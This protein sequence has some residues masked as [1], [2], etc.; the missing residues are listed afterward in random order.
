M[1]SDS[2]H[3]NRAARRESEVGPL[4][5]LLR[6]ADE[7]DFSPGLLNDLASAMECKLQEI[8]PDEIQ[9]L[10]SLIGKPVALLL[11]SLREAADP[12]TRLTMAS[13]FAAT[14]GGCACS[15]DEPPPPTQAQEHEAAGTLVQRALAPIRYLQSLPT[16]NRY[17]GEFVSDAHRKNPRPRLATLQAAH[18]LPA[19]ER[20]LPPAP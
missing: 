14:S 18:F 17:G 8:P 20:L 9:R 3:D 19:N 1:Y 4:A 6:R 11:A 10:E 12:Q 7:D 13:L 16:W 15:G 5:K 2:E